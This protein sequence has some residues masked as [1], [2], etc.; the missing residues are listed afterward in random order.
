MIELVLAAGAEAPDMRKRVGDQ[1]GIEITDATWSD[2]YERPDVEALV[3][4]Q[5]PASEQ[6]MIRSVFKA[7]GWVVIDKV[8]DTRVLIYP[9]T[10]TPAEPLDEEPL[11]AQLAASW[12]VALPNLASHLELGNSPAAAIAERG[13]QFLASEDSG[14]D[15]ARLLNALETMKRH[16]ARGAQPPI[17]RAGVQAFSASVRPEWLPGVLW[18][19]EIYSQ[20]LLA[21]SYR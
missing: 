15:F 9:A 21:G 11:V 12:I 1:K 13:D 20:R 5:W 4:D 17:R 14:V 3:M 10:I 8:T 2:L 16:N 19:H 7:M 6:F 18:A